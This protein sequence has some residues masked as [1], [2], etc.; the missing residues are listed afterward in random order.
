GLRLL[1]TL[2]IVSGG[3]L[4]ADAGATLV[5]KEPVSSLYTRLQQGDLQGQLDRLDRIKPTPVQ[6]RALKQLPDP[7]RR[8][9]F[10]ARS[11]DRKTQEGDALGKLRIDRIGLSSVF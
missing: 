9:A 6:A 4:L 5:W 7:K 10:A 3:L 11:L 8:L 1:S 2:L